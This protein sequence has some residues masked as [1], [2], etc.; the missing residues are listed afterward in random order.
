MPPFSFVVSRG[1]RRFAPAVALLCVMLA[2]ASGTPAPSELGALRRLYDMTPVAEANPVIARV[3]DCKIE[4]PASE[5]RAFAGSELRYTPNSHGTLSLAEKQ[6]LLQKLIGEH[7]LL[8]NG[9][10]QK[11]DQ[12]EGI[13]TMLKQTLEMVLQETMTQKEVIA[14]VARPQDYERRYD[15]VIGAFFEQ[16]N[17][18]VSNEA[19][20][21]FKAAANQLGLAAPPNAPVAAFVPSG[22]DTLPSEIAHRKLARC[23]L[24]TVTIRDALEAL[25]QLPPARRPNLEHTESLSVIL[26]HLMRN[27][28]LAD[29]ARARG[30]E[31][32]P[33]VIANVQINRNVLTRMYAL[34]QITARAVA[35]TKEPDHGKRVEE[36]YRCRLKDMYTAKDADGA[37]HMMSLAGDR[38][39]IENDYFDDLQERLRAE[40]IATLRRSHSV[41]IDDRVLTGITIERSV[42]PVTASP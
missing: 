20:T 15:E 28:L 39:T 3:V 13:K 6:A 23:R 32:L 21:A 1:V 14:K 31:N 37:E 42:P 25:S 10:E 36:W 41:K 26:R 22:L 11:A 38:E 34:D 19:F 16:L 24:G 5:F 9:Y 29:A 35:M 40:T 2:A 8:W 4:I 33:E 17:V 27:V 12:S 30:Y 18:T 7:F